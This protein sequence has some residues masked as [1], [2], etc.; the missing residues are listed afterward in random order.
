M[1]L[2]TTA[3]GPLNVETNPSLMV[4]AAKA[5]CA[6]ASAVAPASQNDVL[7]KS[8]LSYCFGDVFF[9][10]SKANGK[11]DLRLPV[12]AVGDLR[13]LMHHSSRQPRM[14]RIIMQVLGRKTATLCLAGWRGR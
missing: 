13:I 8:P 1:S 2:P 9:A 11:H 12:E 3:V 10:N 7:M 6:S 5:G 14:A 4:S